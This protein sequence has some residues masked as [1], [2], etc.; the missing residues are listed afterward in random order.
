MFL[1]YNFNSKK[2]KFYSV[3]LFTKY[4]VQSTVYIG[5]KNQVGN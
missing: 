1:L 3:I 5:T 4:I 2:K